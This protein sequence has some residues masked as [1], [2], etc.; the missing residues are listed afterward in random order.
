M[1][2]R[3]NIDVTA[4]R[5]RRFKATFLYC[6]IFN[7]MFKVVSIQVSIID[8]FYGHQPLCL[9][10]TVSCCFHLICYLLTR[11]VRLRNPK[12]DTANEVIHGSVAN[13]LS[14]ISVGNGMLRDIVAATAHRRGAGGPTSETQVAGLSTITNYVLSERNI[15][16]NF[17][18]HR[19]LC[20]VLLDNILL[21]TYSTNLF[22]IFII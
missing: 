3:I 2:R 1:G 6:N 8:Q 11:K 12:K 16:F 15:I 9:C 21:K 10:L 17:Q 19:I 20:Y 13:S 14:T 7:Y 18:K 22:I 4:K 5:D